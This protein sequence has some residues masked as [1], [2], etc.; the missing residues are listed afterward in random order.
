ME[1]L[2]QKDFGNEIETFKA[3]LN[4]KYP[5]IMNVSGRVIDDII[6]NIL[7][8][9]GGRKNNEEGRARVKRE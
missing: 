6:N 3:E 2:E 1:G 5:S 7:N 4:A 9:A 8:I